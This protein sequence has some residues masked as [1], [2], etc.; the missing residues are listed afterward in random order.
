MLKKFTPLIVSF[1]F[2]VIISSIWD[3]IRLPY[4]ENNPIFGEYFEKKFNPANEVLR[5]ILI[6][7]IPTLIYLFIFLKEKT[8]LSLKIT[9][10]KYF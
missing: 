8:A 10:D 9:S 4:D 1:I 2:F 6:I 7:G 3:Y 5:F